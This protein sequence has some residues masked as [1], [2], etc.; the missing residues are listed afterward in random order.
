MK[1]ADNAYM[2]TIGDGDG[3]FYPALVKDGASLALI[4][5]GFAEQNAA[6]VKAIEDEGFKAQDISHIILTHQDGDHMDGVKAMKELA[7]G[8]IVV[9]HKEE[10]P[11]IDGSRTPSKLQAWIDKQGSLSEE[12][13]ADV[14]QRKAAAAARAVPVD[15]TVTDGEIIFGDMEAVHV[16]GHTPGHIVLYLKNSGIIIG[17]DAINI[18]DGKLTGPN[19]AYTQDPAQGAASLE[20]ILGYNPK[21][22]VTY[23]CGLWKSED[24]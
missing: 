10:A 9:A 13:K 5:A 14:E 4:D 8:A 2:L 11:Y 22:V 20:K 17:G 18:E 23:H 7:P 19:P 12:D 15:R 6:F 16:P 1:I 21:M 3:A 24:R